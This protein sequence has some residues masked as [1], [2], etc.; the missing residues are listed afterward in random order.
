MCFSFELNRGR[1]GVL[2]GDMTFHIKVGTATSGPT[3][4]PIRVAKFLTPLRHETSESTSENP[5]INTL[6]LLWAT[7][8][9]EVVF[10]ISVFSS[11]TKQ[12][13]LASSMNSAKIVFVGVVRARHFTISLASNPR[14]LIPVVPANLSPFKSK[15]AAF[16]SFPS[17]VRLFTI[18]FHVMS[19]NI[20]F[21]QRGS[22]RFS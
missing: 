4:P 5:H 22:E 21:A 7:N 9:S 12:L 14:I 13:Y 17:A 10:P 2:K 16:F 8:I 6:L 3:C 19:S 18:S 11:T 15:M 1:W 20:T